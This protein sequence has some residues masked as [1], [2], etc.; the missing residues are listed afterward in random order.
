M[1]KVIIFLFILIILV[2]AFWFGLSFNNEKQYVSPETVVVM[3][4]KN[5]SDKN[6]EKAL[7]YYGGSFE[8]LE[9]WNPEISSLNKIELIKT[10]CEQNG[11]NCLPVRSIVVDPSV[12]VDGLNKNGLYDR[13]VPYTVTFEKIG[14]GLFEIGP[15]C[16]EEDNGQRF[17]EF[18]VFIA[19]KN[20]SYLVLTLPPYTP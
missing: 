12:S 1:K 8:T 6:Y 15:C 18:T 14:G 3:F 5:L 13:I 7:E 20:G 16:G 11:L 17:S 9:T 2:L 4:F 19:E 10:G